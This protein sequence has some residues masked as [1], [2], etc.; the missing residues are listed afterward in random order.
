MADEDKLVKAGVEA[1]LKP[2]VDLLEKIA[3]PAAEEIGLTLK[4]HVRVF[5]LKRQVR[6]FNRVKEI[7]AESDLEPGRVPFKL[8]QPIIESASLEEKDELQDRWAALLANSAITR[9]VHPSFPEI[10]K[11]LSEREV[12]YLDAVYEY[13]EG[14]KELEVQRTIHGAELKRRFGKLDNTF[15]LRLA[16]VLDMKTEDPQEAYHN[17]DPLFKIS[18]LGDNVVRLGLLRTPVQDM[19][20]RLTDFGKAFVKACRAPVPKKKI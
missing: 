12:L 16:K 20:H 1:A 10:L 6:L 18:G 14:K 3:G 13:Q 5:R 9:D 11:Q 17:I 15:Y 2:F 4:D 7:L 8:L 19:N